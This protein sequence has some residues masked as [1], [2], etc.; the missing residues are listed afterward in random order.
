[1]DASRANSSGQIS[2]SLARPMTAATCRGGYR[3]GSTF[4]SRS[5][6]VR[7]RSVSPSSEIEKGDGLG[8]VEPLEE[9][10]CRPHAS[11]VG[12]AG[13]VLVGSLSPHEP[14]GYPEALRVSASERT[15]DGASCIR[16]HSLLRG[17]GFERPDRGRDPG[18]R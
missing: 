7:T 3:L 5:T 9:G 8:G 17:P 1:L 6:I 10:G 13:D 14:G 12:A 18:R 15:S 4:S 16:R 2:W 11:I